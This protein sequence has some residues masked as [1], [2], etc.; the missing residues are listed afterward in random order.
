MT[1]LPP[2]YSWLANE[3]HPAILVAALALYGTREIKGDRH[4]PVILSWA[5]E[6]SSQVMSYYTADEIPWC[7]LFMAHVC[8]SAGQPVP[9]GYDALRARGYLTWGNPAGPFPM[10]GDVLVFTRQGGGHVGLYVGED[11]TAFHVLGGNQGDAVSIVR[12]SRDRLDAARRTPW[13]VAQP[14]SVR[15]ILLAPNG[16]LSLNEA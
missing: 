9:A 1:P 15:R 10:L 11:D 7:G 6:L 8:R 13:R 14:K 3:R 16:A 12:I 2:N 5:R 4:N